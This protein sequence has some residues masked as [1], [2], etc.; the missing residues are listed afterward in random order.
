MIENGVT[1]PSPPHLALYIDCLKPPY[2]E[3]DFGTIPKRRYETKF[4]FSQE[5]QSV[6]ILNS[7]LKS[8]GDV[9]GRNS[10]R[11]LRTLPPS[12]H[13][14]HQRAQNLPISIL[15]KNQSNKERKSL[16]Q[17]KAFYVRL[18]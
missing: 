4:N 9:T 17:R 3:G 2:L 15:H 5:H 6:N 14:P 16:S 7:S 13:P 18:T 11:V 10:V 12:L 8:L 1:T